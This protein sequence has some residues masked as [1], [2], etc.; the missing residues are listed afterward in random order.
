DGGALRMSPGGGK[1]FMCDA[2]DHVLLLRRQSRWASL[3]MERDSNAAVRRHGSCERAKG[4]DQA[5]IQGGSEGKTA[6]SVVEPVLARVCEPHDA[7][8]LRR[9]RRL[10]GKLLE[11]SLTEQ[12]DRDEQL[13][14]AVMQVASQSL[15]LVSERLRPQRLLAVGSKSVAVQHLS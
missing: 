14:G 5:T 9:Q 2:V 6:N 15:P 1:R 12:A 8:Q 7:T 10:F 4:G 13:P 11:Q 3:H